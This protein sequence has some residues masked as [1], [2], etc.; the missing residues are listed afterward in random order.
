M[1]TDSSIPAWK[2]KAAKKREEQYSR[3]P[4]GW[5]LDPLPSPLPKSTLAYIES[6]EL[7][8]LTA[9]E[10]EITSVLSAQEL[11]AKIQRHEYS[12]EAVTVAFCKRAAIAHQL[13]GC[14][15]EM[16]FDKAIQQARRLDRHQRETGNVVG[17]LHGLPISLKDNV[18]VEGEDT[19]IGKFFT[20]LTPRSESDNNLIYLNLV[21]LPCFTFLRT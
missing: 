20:G 8:I 12:A 11:L 5:R 14:C 9:E 18:D 7:S 16:F 17:P 21:Y 19:S 15:T 1:T 2:Q 10:R 3:I 6:S 4:V 13:C